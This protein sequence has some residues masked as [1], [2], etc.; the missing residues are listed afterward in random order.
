MNNFRK[1]PAL[2]LGMS[3]AFWIVIGLPLV[4]LFNLFQ[5]SSQPTL[6]F[7]DFLNAV[8]RGH[9][10]LLYAPNARHASVWNGAHRG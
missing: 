6:A 2:W 8:S 4:A 5:T 3:V 9:V 10:D 1:N 7:S